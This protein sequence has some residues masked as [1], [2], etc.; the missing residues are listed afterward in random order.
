[1]GL[2]W[3]QE[4]HLDPSAPSRIHFCSPSHSRSLN[5]HSCSHLEV[6]SRLGGLVQPHDEVVHALRNV[7][8]AAGLAPYNA[9]YPE[10]QIEVPNATSLDDSEDG[11]APKH[12]SDLVFTDSDGS[13]IHLDVSIV[14]TAGMTVRQAAAQRLGGGYGC[15]VQ[16][17]R[18]KLRN[19]QAWINGSETQIPQSTQEEPTPNVTPSDSATGAPPTSPEMSTEGPDSPNPTPTHPEWQPTTPSPSPP[20]SSPTGGSP[21][22]KEVS[23]DGTRRFVPF[24]LSSSGRLGPCA[25]SFFA[26]LCTQAKRRGH[27][28]TALGVSGA[29]DAVAASVREDASWANRNFPAWAKQSVS[30]AVCAT[31]ALA[32]DRILRNDSLASLTQRGKCAPHRPPGVV[33]YCP[34]R[35]AQVKE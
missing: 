7:I 13:V 31:K 9:I 11:E 16:R 22:L 1:M 19:A 34:T 14:N 21:Q 29:D 27:D 6:C 26:R 25:A 2:P 4:P 10:R 15:L 33:G 28:Y 35:H 12:Y 5:A 32:I 17:E 30:F 3:Y 23:A 18:T 24:V 20:A 8:A